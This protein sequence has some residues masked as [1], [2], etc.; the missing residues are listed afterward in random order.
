MRKEISKLEALKTFTTGMVPK[1]KF[2]LV[3][4]R[5][6]TFE[7]WTNEMKRKISYI[8]KQE[9]LCTTSEVYNILSV[10]KI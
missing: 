9:K 3:I 1:V 4:R 7:M 10:F 8:T 2:N 6:L 5:D